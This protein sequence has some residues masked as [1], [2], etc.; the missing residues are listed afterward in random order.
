[1]RGRGRER[2]E[3][4]RVSELHRKEVE[5]VAEPFV[6]RLEEVEVDAAGLVG[7]REAAD[8]ASVHVAGGR[9][10]V[11]RVRVEKQ[12]VAYPM[13]GRGREREEAHR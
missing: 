5:G 13:R 9:L 6:E 7:R 12:T 1:M 2:K 10:V 8:D 11:R 3:G 4:E